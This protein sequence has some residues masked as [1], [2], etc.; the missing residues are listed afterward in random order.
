MTQK[1]MT[2]VEPDLT[3]FENALTQRLPTAKSFAPPTARSIRELIE[4]LEEA[5]AQVESR[6][7]IIKDRLEHFNRLQTDFYHGPTP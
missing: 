5:L 1:D 2:K 3:A 7:R 4:D 6:V